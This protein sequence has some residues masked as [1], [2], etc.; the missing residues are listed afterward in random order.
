MKG[1][2]GLGPHPT[3][4]VRMTGCQYPKPSQPSLAILV[5]GVDS[6]WTLRLWVHPLPPFPTKTPPYDP[7]GG[8]RPAK[9]SVEL[10]CGTWGVQGVIV[11]GGWHVV[12]F[13]QF[14]AWGP[15]NNLWSF[16][17]E[18]KVSKWCWG[19]LNFEIFLCRVTSPETTSQYKDTCRFRHAV[20]GYISTLHSRVWNREC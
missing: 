5:G 18:V 7:L 14:F 11:V 1:R 15:A 20:A 17:V 6:S 16:L 4:D 9:V 10:W 19:L 8:K 13:F 3:W 12:F 2:Y